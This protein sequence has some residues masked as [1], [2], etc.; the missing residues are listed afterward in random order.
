ME[1]AA[2]PELPSQITC[3]EILPRLPSKSLMRF[4]CVCKSWSS[5]TRDPSFVSAH[6]NLGCNKNTHLLLTAWDKPTTQQ[7]FFSLEINQQGSL[8]PVHLLS[9]PTPRTKNEHLYHVQSINGLVCLY[10]HNTSVP[11]Q[12]DPEHPIRVFNPSTRESI[13]LPHA[14][15]ASHTANV[16]QH[17]G[18]SPL[19]NEYKVL[20]VQKL[21]PDAL[22]GNHFVFKIFKLG[23]SS[24]RCIEVDLN[25]L[26]F[27]PL[28][29]PFHKRSVCVNGAVHWM[30]GTE[31]VIV[32][33]DIGEEKFRA[34]PLP[35]DYNC[36]IH[37]VDY[38]VGSV[39][40]VDGCVALIGD[41][42]LMRM[43]MIGLWILRDYQNQVWVKETI[44]FPFHWEKA[45]YPV[46]FCTI[47]T[48]ELLLH[49]SRLS[50]RKPAHPRALLYN[51][52][53]ESFRESDEIVLPPESTCLNVVRLKLLANYDDS[54]VPL[55]K[56]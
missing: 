8:I 5:L 28:N 33:F 1:P 14:S 52:E 51:M 11:N 44:C 20:Q 39:V 19:T 18:F 30:H 15:L 34:I 6:Q 29:C 16:T 10:L 53:S 2:G 17:F 50:R 37:R 25:D 54:I 24:W 12:T 22:R 23:T 4:R 38:P 49:S 46:P 56:R 26:P 9:L 35:E 45:G 13:T 21:I 41:K 43:G 32:V 42:R 7:H 36:F 55:T 48:G 27:D 31:N 3:F 40:E 47:H